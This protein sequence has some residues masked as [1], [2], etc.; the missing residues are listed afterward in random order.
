MFRFYWAAAQK[1]GGAVIRE[2]V[3]RQLEAEYGVNP[4][5]YWKDPS[6]AEVEARKAA[7]KKGALEVKRELLKTTEG[8]TNI[9]TNARGEPLWDDDVHGEFVVLVVKINKGDG[10]TEY[11]RI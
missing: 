10:L 5:R 4:L 7:H 2:D 8:R 3:G 11:G 6:P 9:K 1:T